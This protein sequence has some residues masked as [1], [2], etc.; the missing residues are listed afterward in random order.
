MMVVADIASGG[1][2]I[3]PKRKPN[4]K[5]KPGISALETN[6]TT[7]EVM[8][9]MGKAKLIITLLHLQNSFHDVAHA[10]SYRSGGKK[11]KKTS[12][13][14]IVTLENTDVKLSSNPPKTSIIGYA[15]LTLFA[16]ITSAKIMRI[17]KIY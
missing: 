7:H 2:M 12:S 8:I 11:I 10:A 3:P 9:T 1:E 16:S 17:R 15:I 14:S 5:V 13:G 4:A 6:A